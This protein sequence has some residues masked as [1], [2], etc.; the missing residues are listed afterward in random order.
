MLVTVE[1]ASKS[2]DARCW[3]H[4]NTSRDVKSSEGAAETARS[5][6]TSTTVRKSATAGMT[7]AQE[8]TATSGDGRTEE[9]P[10]PKVVQMGWFS[11]VSTHF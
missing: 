10:L 6:G 5:P 1:Y 8:T 11:V 7:A 3:K 2:R 4:C 9:I